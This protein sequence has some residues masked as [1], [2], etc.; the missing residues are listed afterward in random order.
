MSIHFG[1]PLREYVKGKSQVEVA[2]TLGVTQG[3]ISQ[4]LLSG[5]DVRVV[6][7]RNG[8]AEG[9]ELRRIGS[10]RKPLAA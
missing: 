8:K 3:A 5:R 10:R 6:F 9:Y 4:M 2:E 7:D 1:T